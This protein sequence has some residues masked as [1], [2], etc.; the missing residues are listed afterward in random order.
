MEKASNTLAA[1][2]EEKVERRK[3]LLVQCRWKDANNEWVLSSVMIMDVR[4]SHDVAH[5]V[6]RR[7]CAPRE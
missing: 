4:T 3:C 5:M 6:L 2:A 7:A 1:E